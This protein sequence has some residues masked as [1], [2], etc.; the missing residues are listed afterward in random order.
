[1]N[2][3]QKGLLLL[4]K[5]AITGE[6]YSLFD[7]IN[8]QEV[9]AIAQRHFMNV[10]VY[11]GAHNCGLL[12]GEEQAQ[13]VFSLVCQEMVINETQVYAF[14]EIVSKFEENS[15]DYLPL[16]GSR[17]KNLYPKPEMRSMSDIDILIKLSQYE[18]ISKIMK[19]LGYESV[20]ESDHEL[21]WKRDTIVV[22]LHKRLIPSYNK[23][24]Y[25]YF[26]DG[27][28]LAVKNEEK[29]GEHYLKKEDELIFLFTHLCKHYRDSGIGIKHL[30]DIWTFRAINKNLDEEY[31]KTEMV[32]LKIYEFYHNVLNTLSVW[33]DGADG[34]EITEYI[35]EVA[36]N[37]GIFNR[38]KAQVLSATLK[39]VKEGKSVKQLKKEKLLTGVFTPYNV[40]CG[41]YPFLRKWKILL[42][43]AWVY[44]L[45][46]RLFTK[47]K[48]KKYNRQLSDMKEKDVEF[49]QKSLNFVGLDYNFNEDDE[50]GKE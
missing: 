38:E 34:N 20:I 42:P 24:Y 25:S 19:E 48:L 10:L 26:G 15:V 5:S 32:K 44:H 30:L 28:R 41:F 1:M 37:G 35:T 12:N 6:K 21:I 49:Y 22:E 7:G 43:F 33:F 47:G 16:K 31:V 2:K 29:N 17:L 14:N 3:E 46:R 50:K 18:V 23:D 36:F 8:M 13:R 4:V 45:F 40:M 27:W 39:G 9:F 11:N